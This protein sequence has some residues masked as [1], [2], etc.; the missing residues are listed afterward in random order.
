M[1]RRADDSAMGMT[2]DQLSEGDVRIEAKNDLVIQAEKVRINNQELTLPPKIGVS[3]DGEMRASGSTINLL[4]D[5]NIDFWVGQNDTSVDIRV[6][7]KTSNEI[8]APTL[9]NS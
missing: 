5:G 6:T 2:F 7:N 1:D 8:F 4:S 9:L 3:V